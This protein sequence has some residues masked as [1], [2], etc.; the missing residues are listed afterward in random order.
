NNI[1]QYNNIYNNTNNGIQHNGTGTLDATYNW[2]GDS[3]GPSGVGPGEGDAVSENVKYNPWL[4]NPFEEPQ[5]YYDHCEALNSGWN[6]ISTPKILENDDISEMVA[7]MD[8]LQHVYR[9][10][11]SGWIEDN[12]AYGQEPLYASFVKVKEEA[13]SI[14]IGYNWSTDP[15]DV[16]PSR[17]LPEGWSMIGPSIDPSVEPSVPADEFLDSVSESYSTLFSPDFNLNSWTVTT[18]T[19]A[20]ENVLPFEGYWI[21]MESLDTL[22]GRTT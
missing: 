4:L 11:N 20:D 9:Y 14:G 5:T 18:K 1:V 17:D 7:D 6:L 22:A 19:A 8:N 16:P 15:Q 21:F 3:S 13:G 2:W 12:A 10:E